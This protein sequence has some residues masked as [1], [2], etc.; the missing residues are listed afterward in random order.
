MHTLEVDGVQLDFGMR[1]ILND[2]YVRCDTG[3][4]T[5]LLGRNGAGKTC[6]MQV[7][8][9]TLRAYSSSVRCD[10]KYIKQAYTVKGLINYLPQFYFIPGNMKARRAFDYYNVSP[11]TFYEYFPE[12]EKETDKQMVDLSGGQRRLLEV[13][14]I[15][16]AD[17]KFSILDEPFSHIMPLHVDILKQLINK[18]KERK[19]IIVT[20]HLYRH[21][22][23]IS[24]TMYLMDNGKTHRIADA[25][26]LIRY[27]YVYEL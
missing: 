2:V 16:V 22:M 5:G 18:V 26:Q 23:S 1:H 9:G 10:G 3:K 15:L 24:D 13:Y 20:D 25:A 21:I 7:A 19:G 14:L 11:D 6:F 27:G 17:T 4:V 8:F 12:Y